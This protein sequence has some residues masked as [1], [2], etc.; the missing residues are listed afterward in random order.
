M[1]KFVLL[2]ILVV[3]GFS[4]AAQ[5]YSGPTDS[6]MRT[7]SIVQAANVP[8]RL[9]PTRN[10]WNFMKLDTITGQIWMVQYSVEK[11]SSA[12]TWTLDDRKIHC[13]SFIKNGFL[14]MFFFKKNTTFVG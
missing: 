11:S 14:L 9:F 10:N 13:S 7:Y 4:A 1:K 8:F 12:F 5:S 3:A 2:V 6:D